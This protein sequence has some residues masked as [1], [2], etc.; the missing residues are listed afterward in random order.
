MTTKKL[1]FES[2][3]KNDMTLSISQ[4]A[5][6]SSDTFSHLK[7]RARLA[8]ENSSKGNTT[9]GGI[10]TIGGQETASTYDLGKAY[11]THDELSF[12]NSNLNDSHNIE[13][14]TDVSFVNHELSRLSNCSDDD[15]LKIQKLMK[16][17]QHLV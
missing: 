10:T 11:T 3:I 9:F 2:P 14:F 13:Q 7:S 15:S 4:S 17:S 1:R 16:I 6:Q 8:A 12:N 5:S